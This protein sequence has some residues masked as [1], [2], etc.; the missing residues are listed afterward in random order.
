MYMETWAWT[1]NISSFEQRTGIWHAAVACRPTLHVHMCSCIVIHQL[2]MAGSLIHSS[3][4]LLASAT[5]SVTM[6]RPEAEAVHAP[7]SS[8][9]A[10]H[11]ERS[12]PVIGASSGRHRGVIGASSGRRHHQDLIGAPSGL[13]GKR[14]LV[15]HRG[16]RSVRARRACARL[17]CMPKLECSRAGSC[18]RIRTGLAT[19]ARCRACPR[20]VGE[21]PRGLDEGWM[22]VG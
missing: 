10:L 17:A 9:R 3:S 8:E 20:A 21:V 14:G 16:R 13:V 22:R 4:S 7:G 1:C 6:G 2:P 11:L 15:V 18:C 5:P 19:S 12:V